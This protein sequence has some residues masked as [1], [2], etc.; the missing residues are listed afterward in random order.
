MILYAYTQLHQA[1]AHL[2]YIIYS[3]LFAK[4]ISHQTNVAQ[5]RYERAKKI[6]FVKPNGLCSDLWRGTVEGVWVRIARF[7]MG[8]APPPLLFSKNSIVFPSFDMQTSIF[9]ALSCCIVWRRFYSRAIEY[10]AC[11][12][13][14]YPGDYIVSLMH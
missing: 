5:H 14:V 8:R 13:N 7:R 10:L 11:I 3:V 12:V 1:I 9:I 4:A 6:H 2:T